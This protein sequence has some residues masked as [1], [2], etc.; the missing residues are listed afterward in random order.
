MNTTPSWA[1]R[2]RSHPAHTG[3][4][5]D[6]WSRECRGHWCHPSEGHP[7]TS[8]LQPLLLHISAA[9][10]TAAAVNVLGENTD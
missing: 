10:Q 2:S 3:Q 1:T 9:P 6:P 8:V 5:P 4:L 7:V